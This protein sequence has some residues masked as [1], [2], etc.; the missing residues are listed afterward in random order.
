MLDLPAVAN[1]ALWLNEV[2]A[3]G[4]RWVG[5]TT[6]PCPVDLR[7]ALEA[8]ARRTTSVFAAESVEQDL[9]FIE[10]LSRLERCDEQVASLAQG[11]GAGA[12]AA[13]YFWQTCGNDLL[14]NRAL[15]S[16]T[17]AQLT[18]VASPALAQSLWG[19]ISD[20]LSVH[21]DLP[22]YPRARELEFL[23]ATFRYL[24]TL[25]PGD[26]FFVNLVGT[27]LPNWLG[28]DSGMKKVWAKEVTRS[29]A[30][31][32]ALARFFH[33]HRSVPGAAA[34]EAWAARD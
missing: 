24:Q 3:R 17:L 5:F 12:L 11:Q 27:W 19:L 26:D 31:R 15:F 4:S 29:S 2:P 16:K 23:A 9:A 21:Q 25:D 20:E 13:G 32:A 6:V 10:R 8:P 14:A 33:A 30:E 1:G 18:S 28:I 22:Y 7:A 34:L